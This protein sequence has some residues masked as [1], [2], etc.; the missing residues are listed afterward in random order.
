MLPNDKVPFTN[1]GNEMETD[2]DADAHSLTIATCTEP[3]LLGSI[4]ND[5]KASRNKESMNEWLNELTVQPNPGEIPPI[6]RHRFR[7]HSMVL[8]QPAAQTQ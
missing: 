3:R 2:D 5:K 6:V 8:S 4:A 7:A 1:D